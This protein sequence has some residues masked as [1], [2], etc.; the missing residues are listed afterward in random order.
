[1]DGG[2]RGAQMSGNDIVRTTEHAEL[3]GHFD[4][5]GLG[6]G[7]DARGGGIVETEDGGG[8]AGAVEEQIGGLVAIGDGQIA[9]NDVLRLDG[10]ARFVV[11]GAD[12][13]IE[14][15]DVVIRG[16]KGTGEDGDVLVAEAEEII[17]G[18]LGSAGVIGQQAGHARQGYIVPGH[19]YAETAAYERLAEGGIRLAQAE[20]LGGGAGA[21]G[22]RQI[23]RLRRLRNRN[24][25][26]SGRS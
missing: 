8:R 7:D 2:K 20:I 13:V 12:A 21:G 11:P 10:D 22:M 24:R 9:I 25:P 26:G 19:V 16:A 4:A 5:A 17:D 1:M 23:I 6:A 3:L 14:L 15:D 18:S